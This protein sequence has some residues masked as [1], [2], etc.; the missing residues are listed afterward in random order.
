[1]IIVTTSVA[2]ILIYNFFDKSKLF[3]HELDVMD[4][5]FLGFYI[6]IVA[7]IV[8]IV[9]GIDV[10]TGFLSGLIMM[11]GRDLYRTDSNDVKNKKEDGK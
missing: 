1:M 5:K 6:C 4:N 11:Q 2:S 3:S 7:G 8:S 10:I 9:L